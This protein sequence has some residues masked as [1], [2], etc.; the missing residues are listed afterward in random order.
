MRLIVF[1]CPHYVAE[2]FVQDEFDGSFFVSGAPSGRTSVQTLTS[3]VNDSAAQT[4]TL[5][6]NLTRAGGQEALLSVLS[7]QGLDTEGMVAVDGSG[8]SRNNKVSPAQLTGCLVL[9]LAYSPTH[10]ALLLNNLPLAGESGGL[11]RRLRD[12]PAQGRVRAKTGF[13]N[14]T[15]GLSGVV[16][17]RSGQELAFSILVEYP[18]FAGLANSCWKP[19]QD[20][21]CATLASR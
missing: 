1:L 16:Q 3:A 20:R 19:M 21:I 5:S 8:L 17:T 12:T 4:L 15:S 2:Q 13:I 9:A 11:Q 7:R 14:G 18:S 10:R 6:G